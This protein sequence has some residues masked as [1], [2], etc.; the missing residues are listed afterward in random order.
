MKNVFRIRRSVPAELLKDCVRRVK[1]LR[2]RMMAARPDS[3]AGRGR[4]Q[5]ARPCRTAQPPSSDWLSSE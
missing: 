2:G 1:R 4:W 3:E 5:G